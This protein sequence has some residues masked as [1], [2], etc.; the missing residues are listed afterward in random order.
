[1]S[2]PSKVVESST[3]SISFSALVALLQQ[4]FERHGTS[5]EVAAILAHNCAS[6]ERDGAHSHGIFRIPG[7]LSTLAS[8]WVDGRAVP[9]VTDVASGFVRV[10]AGNGF[11]QP[12]LEAARALLVEK[13]RSAGIALLA[14]H[15]SHHFAALWPDVEPFAEQG[16]VALS[17]VNSMTCVVPHGADRPLFGTN[18]IAFAAP[19]ADG[20]PIVFDLATSAIAHGDVQIAA[21]KGERLPPGMGVDGL[22][23]PTQDPKAI[24]EGGALL[25]FGGHKG[26]A[27]SM[28]VELLAAAL[29]GGNFSFEFNWSDHP[30]ARTPWTGQLL[31]VIDPSK[32]AGQS[33][34]ERSQELVR[35]MHAAGLRRLPGDRRHRT[36]AKSQQEGIEIDAEELQQLRKWIL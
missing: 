20:L 26:S 31:I 2:T 12:A 8:G 10:D 17:V 27:L 24:L 36:R 34:A 9:Q 13:A 32:T 4:V 23:Q 15:N 22:G 7:Y 16:L 11:A 3:V 6:A 33:F 1:M 25:P 21:R 28:M 18:P 35:Q 30:G 19:R 14:I 29:T 5:P